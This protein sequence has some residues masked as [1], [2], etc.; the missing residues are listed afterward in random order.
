VSVAAYETLTDLH[1]RH[2]RE[3]YDGSAIDPTVVE[4]RGYRSVTAAEAQALGFAPSQCRSGLFLPTF[5]LAGVRV[6][7]MLKPDEPRIDPKADK[8][9]KYEWPAGEP[10]LVDIHPDALA[11]FK[12]RGV[13]KWWTEGHKKADA[14]WSRGLACANLPGVYMFLHH[15]KVVADLDELDL[16]GEVCYVV[17]DSDVMRKKSVANALLRFCEALRRRGAR[18]MVVYL[19]EG[20]NGAKVGLDDFFATGGTVEQLRA[21]AVR[22]DGTGPGI[23]LRTPSDV[24]PDEQARTISYLIQAIQHPEYTLADLR[25]MAATIAR[26]QRKRASGEVTPDG[27]AILTAAEI[28]DDWRPA[29]EKGAPKIPT[30]PNGTKPRM[31]RSTVKSHMERAVK[32]GLI[33]AEPIPVRRVHATGSR[34]PDTDWAIT[35]ADS[36]AA[37]LAPWATYRVE[38]PKQRKPRTLTPPCKFCGEVHAIERF[39]YC[40]GCGALVDNPT[41]EPIT[42][43]DTA[44]DNLSQA[45]AAAADSDDASLAG[46]T[47]PHPRTPRLRI[48]APFAQGTHHNPLDA[49][50]WLLDAPDPPPDDGDRSPPRTL[51]PL[52]PTGCRSCGAAIAEGQTHCRACDWSTA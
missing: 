37:M 47:E 7:G 26:A 48:V 44:L 6:L 49:P 28:S 30:N 41:I 27:R 33:P 10:P 9:L 22:W 46:D 19:P 14:A 34:Y 13:E 5:T 4:R 42:A 32:R 2:A 35:T 17:F 40:Q 8:P 18:V 1:P 36:L 12:T 51:F 25:L 11:T 15:R 39:D 20:E 29:P 45:D 16:A 50:G 38:T 43:D 24:D 52:P 21:L 31:A 3:L 23:K